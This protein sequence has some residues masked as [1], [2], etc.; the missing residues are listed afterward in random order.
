MVDFKLVIADPKN[1]KSYKKELKD[2][3][4]TILIGKKIGETVEIAGLQGYK[5]KITGGSDYAGFPMRHDIPG[6]GRKRIYAKGGVG[7]RKVKKG[8]KKRKT[9]CGN[10]IHAKIAQ[11]N[12]KII[13]YGTKPLGEAKE[14][15]EENKE[16][17]TPEKKQ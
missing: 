8:E 6:T 4:A 11:I 9:V 16:A 1:G 17:K 3:D 14:T 7:I 2:K 5:L 15:K 10:T 12:L 13:E